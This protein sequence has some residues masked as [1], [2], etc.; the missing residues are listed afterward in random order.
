MLAPRRLHAGRKRAKSARPNG[1]KT[2]GARSEAGPSCGCWTC[3]MGGDQ[4]VVGRTGV[5]EELGPIRCSRSDCDTW[6]HQQPCLRFLLA[7]R[8]AG[9]RTITRCSLLQAQRELKPLRP[10]GDIG[11]TGTDA[12]KLTHKDQSNARGRLGRALQIQICSYAIALGRTPEAPRS[13]RVWRH[14][15]PTTVV[16]EPA[17]AA[18]QQPSCHPTGGKA[19]QLLLAAVLVPFTATVYDCEL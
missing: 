11:I 14:A 18:A 2:E 13:W 12:H 5:S 19:V 15:R 3:R 6:S 1:L 4:A 16:P 9:F 7:V 10:Q 17:R 8:H